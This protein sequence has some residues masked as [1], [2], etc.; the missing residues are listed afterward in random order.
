VRVV[1]VEATEQ[2]S[3]S[4]FPRFPQIESRGV[5]T[6]VGECRPRFRGY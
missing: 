4:V 5:D 1:V 6:A 2:F 3:R